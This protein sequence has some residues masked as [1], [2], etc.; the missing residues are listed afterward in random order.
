[1][2]STA[3]LGVAKVSLAQQ[4]VEYLASAQNSTALGLTINPDISNGDSYS[5]RADFTALDI[6]LGVGHEA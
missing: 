1:M 5:A 2:F 4:A 6:I 3:R